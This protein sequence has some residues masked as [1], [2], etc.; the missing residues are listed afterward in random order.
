MI[1][2]FTCMV[3]ACARFGDSGYPEIPHVIFQI[4]HRCQGHKMVYGEWSSHEY[5]ALSENGVYPY[6]QW[7]C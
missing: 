7:F 3:R 4:F 5:V 1:F 6:T 2:P